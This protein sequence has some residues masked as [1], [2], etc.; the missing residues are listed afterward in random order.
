MIGGE[1][2]QLAAPGGGLESLLHLSELKSQS[3]Q[4]TTAARRLDLRVERQLDRLAK[5]GHRRPEL[6]SA[7]EL[8]KL[9]LIVVRPQGALVVPNKV[10][11]RS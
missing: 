10:R 11:H 6:E 7:A 4:A 9:L 2:K 8:A 3:L 5:V 1:E